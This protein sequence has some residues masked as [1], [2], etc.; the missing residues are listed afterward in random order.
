MTG[1][2]R[3]PIGSILYGITIVL[4]GTS[5]LHAVLS[6]LAL[7]STPAVLSTQPSL[8]WLLSFPN[9]GT[10]Y[11]L[12]LVRRSTKTL[13]ATNYVELRPETNETSP[14]FHDAPFWADPAF[15]S[16]YTQP[17]DLIMT[18]THCGGYCIDCG[19][20]EYQLSFAGFRDACRT[21]QGKVKRRK[22][23]TKYP[24]E[25]VRKTI[26]LIRDPLDN[27]VS[28]FHNEWYKTEARVPTKEDFRS[29]CQRLDDKWRHEHKQVW[30]DNHSLQSAFDRVPCYADLIRYVEWHNHAFAMTQDLELQTLVVHYESYSNNFDETWKSIIHFLNL[31]KIGREHV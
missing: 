31:K 16:E 30:G 26:H 19:P 17:A 6:T 12:S 25:K 8:V 20:S 29:F 2:R 10:S 11:T 27:V 13:T 15:H 24:I 1:L 21:A 3:T 18:K 5:I 14:V 22:Y 7:T 28:R 23:T 4:I 9:S